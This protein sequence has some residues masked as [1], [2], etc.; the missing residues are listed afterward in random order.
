[1]RQEFIVERNGKQFVLYAGLL[2]LAHEQ[3]LS[4]I[5][6]EVV[7]VPSADNGQFA[8]VAATVVT[9]KGSFSGIGDADPSNVTRLMVPHILRMAETRAKARALRDAVNVG[10]AAIEELGEEDP[11]RTPGALSQPRAF[12]HHNVAVSAPRIVMDPKQRSQPATEKQMDALR[13]ILPPEAA[14]QA[15][16]APLTMGEASELISQYGGTSRR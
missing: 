16:S 6:T 9:E 4:Q 10:T 12:E 7:Q 11:T 5:H 15:M 2:D 13:K 14:K 1:M 8:V 3:G